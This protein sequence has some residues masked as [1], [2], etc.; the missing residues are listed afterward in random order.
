[1]ESR[2]LAKSLSFLPKAVITAARQQA[3]HQCDLDH[4]E[5]AQLH[6]G[7]LKDFTAKEKPKCTIRNGNGT[8]VVAGV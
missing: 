8:V 5:I 7:S 1:M 6:F 3:F 4:L 2:S